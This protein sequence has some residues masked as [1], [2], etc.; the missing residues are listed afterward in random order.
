MKRENRKVIKINLT[1]V[2]GVR[3]ELKEYVG[4]KFKVKGFV[5]NTLGYRGGKRL[6][7]E[8]YLD[9]LYLKHCWM[10]VN[11]VGKLNHGYQ[12]LEVEVIQ[13]Q[14]FI[15][16]EYKYSLKYIGEKGKKFI[17][18]NIKKPKWMKED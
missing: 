12:I 10:D 2:T 5:T 1:E 9:N 4:Q 7:S 11:D 13:Y 18:E 6:I 14:D 8:V 3:N 17:E 16:K 15:S